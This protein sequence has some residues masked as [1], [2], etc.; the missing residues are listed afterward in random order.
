MARGA[1]VLGLARLERKLKRMPQVAKERIRAEMEATANEIVA[2]MK[3]LAPVLKEPHTKREP[4]ALRDSIGWTWGKPPRYS[5]VVAAV[6]ASTADGL[7]LTIY[8]GN[9]AVRYAHLVEFG[10]A[11]HGAAQPFFYVSWRANRKSAGR[12]VRK[13]VREAAR[14]VAGGA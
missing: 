6:K 14:E 7:T 8:A 5:S 4:G 3:N 13:A 12:R 9:N 2:M 11:H 10:T 1:T